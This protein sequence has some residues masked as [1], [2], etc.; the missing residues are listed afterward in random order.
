MSTIHAKEMGDEEK[1][2]HMVK[3]RHVLKGVHC[4]E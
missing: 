1:G 4:C 3:G 2:R